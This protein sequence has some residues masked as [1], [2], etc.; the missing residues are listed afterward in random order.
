[1]IFS[2]EAFPAEIIEHSFAVFLGHRVGER[3]HSFDA[4]AF[5]NGNTNQ[6]SAVIA[7]TVG[8]LSERVNAIKFSEKEAQAGGAQARIEA[9]V[10][11]LKDVSEEMK[12][13]TQ[14]EPEDYHWIIVSELLYV[15]GSL[16]DHYEN[17]QR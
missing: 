12:K 8:K 7:E 11:Q 1:M 15:I 4:D 14:R 13:S 16:L 9:A 6:L 2:G 3:G 10:A 17:P 5:R